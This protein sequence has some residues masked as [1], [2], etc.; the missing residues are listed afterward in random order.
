MSHTGESHTTKD[1]EEIKRWVEER[2]GKPTIVKG[3]ENDGE[4]AG[5]LRIDFPGYSGASSL[6]PVSWDEFFKTFDE[7][8]LEFLYQDKTS[9]GEVSRFNKFISTGDEHK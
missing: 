1:H 3:T 2:G 7:K 4:G 6:E 8:N 9:D 5:L